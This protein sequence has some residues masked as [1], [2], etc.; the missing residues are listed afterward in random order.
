MSFE[1]K[2]IPD[3]RYPKIYLTAEPWKICHTP[4]PGFSFNP[5]SWVQNYD[6]LVLLCGFN[7]FILPRLEPL[8]PGSLLYFHSL[9]A[10]Q[11]FQ[12]SPPNPPQTPGYAK[13]GEEEVKLHHRGLERRPLSSILATVATVQIRRVGFTLDFNHNTISPNYS[14]SRTSPGDAA[15]GGG[16][17]LL[18]CVDWGFE[19]KP[20]RLPSLPAL[21]SVSSQRNKD[22]SITQRPTCDVFHVSSSG[23]TA[24]LNVCRP[25]ESVMAL[26]TSSLSLRGFRKQR[27]FPPWRQ[28]LISLISFCSRIIYKINVLIKR[29]VCSSLRRMRPSTGGRLSFIASTLMIHPREELN[30]RN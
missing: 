23:S 7:F 29:T 21:P 16:G 5:S 26:H 4:S 9:K 27:R 30:W 11:F 28:E 6:L 12:N 2:N 8:R 24:A 1:D 17:F 3:V 14:K 13:V 20:T 10:G 19:V 25:H 22:T 18:W 15:L